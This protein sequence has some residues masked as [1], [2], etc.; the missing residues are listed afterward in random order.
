[1]QM[2][3]YLLPLSALLSSVLSSTYKLGSVVQGDTVLRTIP[4]ESIDGAEILKYSTDLTFYST[5]E[6]TVFT[7]KGPSNCS[8]S[9]VFWD[10]AGEKGALAAACFDGSTY[11]WLFYMQIDLT[12]PFKSALSAPILT[13]L[14]SQLSVKNF[15]GITLISLNELIVASATQVGVA[16]RMIR[17]T[18][19][20]FEGGSS[21]IDWDTTEK[22]PA[23]WQSYS[24]S[25]KFVYTSQT[26]YVLVQPEFSTFD[27]NNYQVLMANPEDVSLMKTV[28]LSELLEN[29]QLV[30]SSDIINADATRLGISVVILDPNTKRLSLQTCPVAK[31]TF[32]LDQP[33][34]H[35]E[36][37][38]G[39]QQL[40]S[41]S[42][43]SQND[44]S[45]VA[46]LYS[47]DNDDSNRLLV[48]STAFEQSAFKTT[49]LYK[50]VLTIG[51]LFARIVSNGDGAVVLSSPSQ[52]TK[53]SFLLNLGSTGSY[54]FFYNTSYGTPVLQRIITNS[55]SAVSM[56]YN[57]LTC[58]FSLIVSLISG[59]RREVII[60]GKAF[61]YPR[62]TTTT[63]TVNTLTSSSESLGS[64]EITLT[65]LDSTNHL[66][67]STPSSLTAYSSQS[68]TLLSL[69]ERLWMGN[70][71]NPQLKINA[72]DAA[73]SKVRSLF[74]TEIAPFPS[75]NPIS[76]N[77]Y[78]GMISS[79]LFITLLDKELKIYT[80]KEVKTITLDEQVKFTLSHALVG[81]N[82]CIAYSGEG[83]DLPTVILDVDLGS[84]QSPKVYKK[85]LPNTSP[86]IV[87]F[88]KYKNKM[89]YGVP[90]RNNKYVML[91]YRD[92]TG[93]DQTTF[94]MI[95]TKQPNTQLI[96]FAAATVDI[97]GIEGYFDV[98]NDSVVMDVMSNCPG[99]QT[100]FSVWHSPSTQ[101]LLVYTEYEYP[102]QG[103]LDGC[104]FK[105][106][107]IYL[108]RRTQEVY[109][110]NRTNWQRSRVAS[111]LNLGYD[112][113][114]WFDCN[115]ANQLII[116]PAYKPS[117]NAT[118]LYVIDGLWNNDN[119][120]WRIRLVATFPDTVDILRSTSTST[121]LFITVITKKSTNPS[122]PFYFFR[123]WHNNRREYIVNIDD[124]SKQI[125]ASADGIDGQ[126]LANSWA[127]GR[128][129]NR[130]GL[131][132]KIYANTNLNVQNYSLSQL[133]QTNGSYF[134]ISIDLSTNKMLKANVTN[135]VT[136]TNRTDSFKFA[137]TMGSGSRLIVSESSHV[138]N[139]FSTILCDSTGCSLPSSQFITL[140][141]LLCAHSSEDINKS[142]YLALFNSSA[143]TFYSS[144]LTPTIFTTEGYYQRDIIACQGFIT[145]KK[146]YSLV[147]NNVG[148]YRLYIGGEGTVKK[149]ED[150]VEFVGGRTL[151]LISYWKFN[152]VH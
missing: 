148:N 97:C 38:T 27:K 62:E 64:D 73:N 85:V 20:S 69:E 136:A 120:D 106:R 129:S 126:G 99:S 139:P 63:L 7:A 36:A 2:W 68:A 25:A 54:G 15:A 147:G 9:S 17:F 44:V 105:E 40:R 6:Q 60:T 133:I 56:A 4:L 37:L 109:S 61:S 137:R 145:G 96:N 32:A 18:K 48:S 19:F 30:I 76:A 89:Y 125:F 71:I 75:M 130:D 8:V 116:I 28:D 127:L 53:P 29:G 34:C 31:D 11:F 152:R 39:Y 24:L 22:I 104:I 92:L 128:S 100:V 144:D 46:I 150:F 79:N 83:A 121:E 23:D 72:Q 82:L 84:G 108:D 91:L 21:N 119:P 95:T 77:A 74:T 135:T 3:S 87:A 138:N 93:D 88:L 52:E 123:Y 118:D 114:T 78:A 90:C 43:H 102:L 51:P 50:G 16:D 42:V 151:V 149:M 142:P 111:L 65:Q 12:Q 80:D 98:R 124:N 45:T 141:N 132:T 112:R 103:S 1:M 70:V 67:S 5:N 14:T 41:L 81:Q 55:T 33:N 110:L 35:V 26:S 134:T 117:S 122:R 57:S 101:S 59:T 49:S 13:N 140:D 143:I 115:E 10:G 86:Y 58:T 131:S 47:E 107:L 146:F 113:V 94:H 66:H